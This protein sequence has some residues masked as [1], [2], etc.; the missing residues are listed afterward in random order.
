MSLKASNTPLTHTVYPSALFSIPTRKMKMLDISTALGARYYLSAQTDR[1][2][3]L[4]LNVSIA[5]SEGANNP[6]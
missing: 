3:N 6:Y 5:L 2:N 4:T 1:V